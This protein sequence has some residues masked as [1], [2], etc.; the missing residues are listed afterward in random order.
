MLFFLQWVV[1]GEGNHLWACLGLWVMA[2]GHLRALGVEGRKTG[3]PSG[4]EE[5]LDVPGWLGSGTEG[6]EL[7]G[8][9]PGRGGRPLGELC[10]GERD[11]DGTGGGPAL[12]GEG[13]PADGSGGL[14][15]AGLLVGNLPVEGGIGGLTALVSS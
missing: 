12:P 3:T 4:E 5:G 11:G 13:R 7:D 2:S 10:W 9:P 8:R 15:P 14:I 6:E 1:E